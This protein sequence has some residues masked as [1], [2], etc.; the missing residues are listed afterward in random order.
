LNKLLDN[1]SLKLGTSPC[2]PI[3][4]NLEVHPLALCAVE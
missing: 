3:H 2:M 1:F 4:S